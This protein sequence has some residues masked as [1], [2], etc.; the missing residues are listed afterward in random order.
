MAEASEF[1]FNLN[2]KKAAKEQQKKKM[3]E[4]KLLRDDETVLTVDNKSD[5]GS[6]YSEES[7][8]SNSGYS[9]AYTRLQ[10][11]MS[12]Q[13]NNDEKCEKTLASWADEMD[14][15]EEEEYDVPD[16]DP[17]DIERMRAKRLAAQQKADKCDNTHELEIKMSA[18]EVELE[19]MKE[20]MKPQGVDAAFN[21]ILRNIDNL[22]TKQKQAL[23]TAIIT[24]M[25]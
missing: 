7:S 25:K 9:D 5:C 24:S 18:L 2:K 1:S 15:L 8:R 20:M 14:R 11:E 19:K 10:R 4:K 3:T 16:T 6:K 23:V 17:R 13:E 22:T 21:T 12:A